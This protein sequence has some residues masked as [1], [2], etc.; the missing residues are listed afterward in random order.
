M[1]VFPNGKI[2]LGLSVLNKREDGFHNIES[3]VYPAPIYDVLEF[4]PSKLF[5][6][7]VSGL[8]VPGEI[9][10][11]ILFNSW[12]FLHQKH[13]V[14]PVEIKI[15]KNIPLGSGL[16]GGSSD[17]AFLLK[18]LNNYYKLNLTSDNLKSY[19]A[20]IGSDCPFFIENK[21][22]IIRGR[23]EDVEQIDLS[24]KG[25][26]II[27]VMPDVQISTKEAF[28]YI[29]K[30]KQKVNLKDIVTKPIE[31][32]Q[33]LLLND[34]EGITFEKYPA[35]KKIKDRLIGEGAVYSSLTGSGSAVFGIFKQAA[36]MNKYFPDY[37]I[38]NG[39]LK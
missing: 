33:D 4:Q 22:S 30:G 32:W 15:L 11:N 9:N 26:Y 3:I 10:E 5:S 13:H 24:L 12:N 37:K 28:Q 8:V 1:I 19:A 20:S 36:N 38:Q 29:E 39:V 25:L 35:L 21:A 23:G 31:Q 14:P 34:F 2:N 17:A 7:E 27:I 16:G 18:T 6:I